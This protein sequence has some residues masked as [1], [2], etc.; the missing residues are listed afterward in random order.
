[1]HDL[2]VALL[3]ELADPVRLRVVDRLGHAGP[4]TVSRLAAELGVSLPQLSNHLRRL[5]EAGLVRGERAGR[6][7][8]YELADPGLEAL[9]PLLDRLTGR[10]APAPERRGEVP[11]RTCYDHL[12]GALGV[13]LYAALCARG[14]LGERPVRMVGHGRPTSVAFAGLGVDV[15]AVRSGRR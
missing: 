10:V 8:V 6:H 1:M 3:R 13:A 12:A 9:L 15:T 14:A 2:R 4:A 7:A 11:S 5:R